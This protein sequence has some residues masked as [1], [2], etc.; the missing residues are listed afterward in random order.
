VQAIAQPTKA[1]VRPSTIVMALGVTTALIVTALVLSR[2][3]PPATLGEA[4]A[5]SAITLPSG[6]VL[7]I[8]L[9]ANPS[10]GYGWTVISMDETILTQVGEAEFTSQSGLIGAAGTMTL[11]FAGLA[12]GETTVE[13]GYLR[14]WEEAEPLDTY[15]VTVTVR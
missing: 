1:P 8:A 11:R 14:P 4:D 12:Q 3:S 7:M 9:P 6:D 15:Q 10:T 5:R 2:D 13:L